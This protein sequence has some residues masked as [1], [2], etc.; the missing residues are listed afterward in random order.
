MAAAQ[1]SLPKGPIASEQQSQQPVQPQVQQP[2][3]PII[4]DGEEALVAKQP[5]Q[6]PAHQPQQS[7]QQQ[8]A[9][10]QDS[11]PKG[12]IATEQQVQQP[13]HPQVQQPARPVVTDGEEAATGS[14]AS[15]VCATASGRCSRLSA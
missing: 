10:A 4:A 14:A 7:V 5:V 2:A 6:Q 11:L 8:V 12:P 1:G 3:R 9:A 15:S 13:A